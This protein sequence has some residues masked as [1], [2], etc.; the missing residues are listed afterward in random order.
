[1]KRMLTT[2]LLCLV[3]VVAAAQ[4]KKPTLMIVPSD[5]WCTQRY[6]TTMYNNQGVKVR[7]PD[8]QRAFQEDIEIKPVIA[9]IGQLLT[10]ITSV[11]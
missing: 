1:M 6:F 9:K 3:T 8:Y 5:N 11:S 10:D 4:E 2:F 7:V